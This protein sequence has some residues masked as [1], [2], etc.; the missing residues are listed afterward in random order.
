MVFA[1]VCIVFGLIAAFAQA[2]YIYYP[3]AP[4]ALYQPGMNVS[5]VSGRTGYYAEIAGYG[6]DGQYNGA[7]G[8]TFDRT[9]KYAFVTSASGKKIRKLNLR[10]SQVG[11]DI[12]SNFNWHYP[13]GMV[14]NY[15]NDYLYVTDRHVISRFAFN[16]QNPVA[17]ESYTVTEICGNIA[18]GF[19]DSNNGTAARF[20][21]PR[22]LDIDEPGRYLYV[23]DTD[24]YRLRR[25]DLQ[26]GSFP[27]VTYANFGLFETNGIALKFDGSA[28]Y[29]IATALNGIWKIPIL[30]N[31]QVYPSPPG[32]WEFITA[33][34]NAIPT[35]TSHFG[36]L[37]DGPVSSSLWFR[38]SS[39]SID[40]HDNLYVIDN[41]EVI[42]ETD[43]ST[44]LA[45]AMFNYAI[46]RVDTRNSFVTTIAGKVCPLVI[47]PTN[48]K[49][50][51]PCLND[52]NG[53]V[54][55]I[56][57]NVLLSVSS[58][59][60]V[61]AKGDKLFFT[62]NG[63]NI[64]RKVEC[65]PF[66]AMGMLYGEC[67][68]PTRSPTIAPVFSSSPTKG[69]TFAPSVPPTVEPSTKPTVSPTS[70]PTFAPS[71]PPTVEPSTKPTVSPTS[72]PTI[73]PTFRPSGPPKACASLYVKTPAGNRCPGYCNAPEFKATFRGARGA[74]LSKG[75]KPID[76]VVVADTG[77]NAI[78]KM[79][80]SSGVV[81]TIASDFKWY[82]PQAVSI[83]AHD[84][85]F[86]TDM[87][88]LIRIPANQLTE[89]STG[90][91]V[92]AGSKVPGDAQSMCPEP[93]PK[94]KPKGRALSAAGTSA[95]SDGAGAGSNGAG[96]GSN[97][98]G[99][100]AG[101]NGAGADAGS[102][103]GAGSNG[104]GAGSD[105]VSRAPAFG[106]GSDMYESDGPQMTANGCAFNTPTGLDVDDLHQYV[107]VVDSGNNAI[108]R[109]SINPDYT[110]S[111]FD[112]ALTTIAVNP[113]LN[114]P[115]GVVVIPSLQVIY[116]TSFG[117]H[118]VFKFDVSGSTFPLEVTKSNIYA[119]STSGVFG[120]VDASFNNAL[121]FNPTGIAADDSNNLYFNEWYS[122]PGEVD[123]GS[124][125]ASEYGVSTGESAEEESNSAGSVVHGKS[126]GGVQNGK[127]VGGVANGKSA[128]G[129]PN[130]KSAAVANGKSNGGSA[131]GMSAG[132]SENGKSAGGSKN[133]NSGSEVETV[134]NGPYGT[135][136]NVASVDWGHEKQY[137]HNVR[138]IVTGNSDAGQVSTIAGSIIPGIFER[139]F[140]SSASD[141]SN[142]SSGNP[143][144][145][146][147]KSNGSAGKSNTGVSKQPSVDMGS[148]G[149][150]A[151]MGSVGG[152]AGI[153]SVGGSAG[154]GSAAGSNSGSSKQPASS[155]S[156]S[157]GTHIRELQHEDGESG[158]FTDGY[159]S[160]SSKQCTSC[161]YNKNRRLAEAEGGAGKGDAG[162]AKGKGAGKGDGKSHIGGHDNVA[163]HDVQASASHYVDGHM[164]GM[165]A[166]NVDE[167]SSFDDGFAVYAR[168][169]FP[170]AITLRPDAST[171]W[172]ADAGNNRIRN[173]SCSG[174]GAPTFDPTAVPSKR[175]TALPT[176]V[177]S[178][179]PVTRKPSNAPVV[180]VVKGP[181][182][183]KAD[184]ATKAPAK[185]V[186]GAS[187]DQVG[188]S[189]S[190][191]SAGM[192][193]S[194]IA[195]ICVVASI[196]A[197][198]TM[199][200]FYNRGAIL[201]IV[202]GSS[203]PIPKAVETEE[204]VSN[205]EKQ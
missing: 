63:N 29:A 7:L 83:D 76:Y 203:N 89:H 186:K 119:G 30:A 137:L 37:K 94:A 139:D 127:T 51:G 197:V 14:T 114:T 25:I 185:G 70:G 15:K 169:F 91:I 46:R 4:N 110:N 151:G 105:A 126:A 97:G 158:S 87:N 85:V 179:K 69:P 161:E 153:G 60:S 53:T 40:D 48:A 199:I 143:N 42:G 2:D 133:G 183:G 107:Y 123:L 146:A 27:V 22:Y 16:V 168:F 96:A 71:V 202:L 150:S 149:G 88:R 160:Y 118:C 176:A 124:V 108:K 120:H 45:P 122:L 171:F 92:I 28:I 201:N 41:Y 8:I 61:G 95:G 191:N 152:S 192:S 81:T 116:V 1:A 57:K 10:T 109:V 141:V 24:N 5:F 189:I 174:V 99:V 33:P 6:S 74:D 47:D 75:G 104:A 135:A 180:A 167:H 130:G 163:K 204:S 157:T 193:T 182:G 194:T 12:T 26:G 106:S 62:D 112:I 136:S 67:F 205:H 20:N 35:D 36:Q 55:G 3:L 142:G 178:L 17:Q 19:R 98:A 73:K 177:P 54:A 72:G 187:V 164:S 140:A 172:I 21:E 59:L 18:L 125:W 82:S 58:Y 66:D 65:G 93:S 9:E 86:V 173:I 84:N 79:V 64:V 144:G 100:G 175:P 68:L 162:A 103:A 159:Y 90:I 50:S 156:V 200:A 121:L 165:T 78:R 128:A 188:Y 80:V 147:G 184:P 131:N 23:S 39:V 196:G 170:Y 43:S 101:S 31:A 13:M 132:G 145:S 38:P 49:A 34:T 77:N 181:G 166:A 11:D 32:G 138:K 52:G 115:F 190:T 154:K 155:A 111:A 195:I 117:G 134:A 102:D 198:A 44:N 56:C 148:A 129:V 113:L